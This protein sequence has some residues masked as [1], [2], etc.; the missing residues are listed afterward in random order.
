MRLIRA[1]LLI[2]L[3]RRIEKADRGG[4]EED[5]LTKKVGARPRARHG[6]LAG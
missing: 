5:R 1:L 3:G 2:G 4:F 6:V